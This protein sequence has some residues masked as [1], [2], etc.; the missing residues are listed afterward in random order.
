[1][2]SVVGSVAALVLIV[3]ASPC[4]AA[5][6]VVEPAVGG[7]A[8]T[9]TSTTKATVREAADLVAQQSM[10]R[11]TARLV[12]VTWWQIAIGF[13]SMLGLMWTLAVT[14]SSARMQLRAYL[15]VKCT[16]CSKIEG[17]SVFRSKLSIQNVG[18]T[19]AYGISCNYKVCVKSKSDVD[20]YIS[21]YSDEELDEALTLGPNDSF[22]VN[23]V[24]ENEVTPGEE[25]DILSENKVVVVAGTVRY[26]DVFKRNR[27]VRFA[28]IHGGVDLEA[29]RI[30]YHRLGNIS[31]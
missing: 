20:E 15:I 4:M 7:T 6:V 17:G 8:D 2:R 19:P 11:S 28:V 29:P 3:S 27:S 21:S 1:M 5:N 14:R 16:S 26:R 31:D 13:V 9:A 30:G 22:G 25:T 10:A 18:Q 23:I 24:S 12:T